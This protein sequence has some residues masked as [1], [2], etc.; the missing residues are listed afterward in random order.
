MFKIIERIDWLL[1]LL[2]Y[3][4]NL[5]PLP[6]KY[7]QNFMFRTECF[8]WHSVYILEDS[9]SVVLKNV[10]KYHKI[11]GSSNLINLGLNLVI[12]S[13]LPMHTF[14]FGLIISSECNS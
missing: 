13:P 8:Q 12:L 2:Y 3:Q 5:F 9:I 1:F 4:C 6:L 14:S 11:S 7:F 10:L